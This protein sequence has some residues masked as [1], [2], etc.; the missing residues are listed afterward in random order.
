MTENDTTRAMGALVALVLCLPAASLCIVPLVVTVAEGLG[1]RSHILVD[2]QVLALWLGPIACV[3]VLC[4]ALLA[5][6]ARPR[7]ALAGLVWRLLQS[8]LAGVFTISSLTCSF[9]ARH[10]LKPKS[11][12]G[13]VGPQWESAGDSEARVRRSRA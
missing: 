5:V 11:F 1:S 3:L 12:R 7:G 4:G 2:A 8:D 9:W 13:L 10:L 6:I